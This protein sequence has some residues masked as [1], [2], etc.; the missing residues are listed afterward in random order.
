MYEDTFVASLPRSQFL[1]D[2]EAVADFLTKRI[3]T[4][5]RSYQTSTDIGEKVDILL[6]LIT[7]QSILSLLN[8]AYVAEDGKMLDA[9]K[10]VFRNLPDYQSCTTD[11]S[12][13]QVDIYIDRITESLQASLA[14][15][16]T[17]LSH[18]TENNSF[19]TIA[20]QIHSET[21]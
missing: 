14:L 10:D 17:M 1:A 9:A 4:A 11:F 15:Q 8:T 7:Y 2:I 21:Y 6:C 13:Q 18:L 3:L 5:N 16:V 12:N 19:T 20:N